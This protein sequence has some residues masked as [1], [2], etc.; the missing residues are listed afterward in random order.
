M[1]GEEGGSWLWSL[2]DELLS[3][4]DAEHPGMLS[5]GGGSGVE[6]PLWV[7]SA[8]GEKASRRETHAPQRSS[9]HTEEP[10]PCTPHR[11]YQMLTVCVSLRTHLIGCPCLSGKQTGAMVTLLGGGRGRCALSC[12]SLLISPASW[13]C[14]EG[15]VAGTWGLHSFGASCG[16]GSGHPGS[17]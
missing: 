1:T 5:Q 9:G 12:P 10:V 8:H 2:E 3:Y 6:E 14:L 7:S 13:R 17:P 11:I 15:P 4:G 16:P